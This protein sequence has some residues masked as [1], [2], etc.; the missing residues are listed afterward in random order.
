MTEPKKTDWEDVNLT[1]LFA[2]FGKY[3]R[4]AGY[5][6]ELCEDSTIDIARMVIENGAVAMAELE[7]SLEKQDD[8]VQTSKKNKEE[9]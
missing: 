2:R 4:L 8:E 1:E 5:T 6:T 3:P 7:E 9:K